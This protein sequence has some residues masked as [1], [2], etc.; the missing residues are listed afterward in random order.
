M[1]PFPRVKT[2]ALDVLARRLARADAAA[3]MSHAERAEL[4]AAE[5]EPER[6]YPLDWIA[7]RITAT[8][9]E[10]A[11]EGGE[12]RPVVRGAD[13]LSDL[14]AMVERLTGA[15]SALPPAGA[16]DSGAVAA[17]WKVSRKTVDRCR[18]RGLV[19]R[20]AIGPRG[21][22][23]LVYSPGVVERF[24]ARH[25]ADLA[26]AGAYTRLDAGEATRIVERAS[27]YARAGLSLNEAAKRL[28]LRHGR[29]HEAVRQ[30][31]LK[32]EAKAERRAFRA[33]APPASLRRRIAYRAWRRGLEPAL[34]AERFGRSRASVVRLINDH[35]AE[36]LLGLEFPE[37]AEPGE[38]HGERGARKWLTPEPVRTEL[39]VPG[40]VD[41]LA[42]IDSARRPE[43]PI[44][45][46][47]STRAAAY[48]YLVSSARRLIGQIPAK[49]GHPTEMDR[50]E[51]MLRWA[52]R[53][54]AELVRSQLGLMVR[55]IE[56]QLG[57]P[58]DSLRA[59]DARE[60]V[61]MGLAAA[62]KAVDAFDPFKKSG[63][64][65]APTGL[66]VN[67]AASRWVRENAASLE[68]GAR[69]TPRL[70]AGTPMADWTLGVALWQGALEPDR[71]VRVAASAG[72]L[73]MAERERGFLVERFGWG[74]GPPRTLAEMA[75]SHRLTPMRVAQRER[76]AIR[77]AL[78]AWRAG[79]R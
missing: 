70:R 25:L 42:L 26:E 35:R 74:G 39:G 58:V 66:H 71:R 77:A 46:V 16:M 28:A 78:A 41:L 34:V 64:L 2:A 13:L 59:A 27:R 40:H 32:A 69:A 67:R 57:C 10:A 11:S 6:E 49:G 12:A 55:T 65:A 30:M 37:H 47:E 44:G 17:R 38:G 43:V 75:G 9:V 5:V 20:R 61:E 54:K 56:A 72:V 79:P 18:R 24:E 76:A 33:P 62:A 8:R 31:L 60:A 21:R 29:S 36:V 1:P 14:S 48:H 15:V 23:M 3:V 53:L 63:R 51:T 73:A 68:R 50:A 19:A 4:L 45:I 22:P 52:A 7:F